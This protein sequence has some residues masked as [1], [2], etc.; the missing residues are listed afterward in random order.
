MC[1][2]ALVW[3]HLSYMRQF[4]L[5][6]FFIGSA[7]AVHGQSVEGVSASLHDR[8]ALLAD[9]QIKYTMRKWGTM[10]N[11]ERFD[12]TET[13]SVAYS[14]SGRYS[15]DKETMVGGSIVAYSVW[16]DG[17]S[18]AKLDSGQKVVFVD[19]AIKDDPSVY[20]WT[21]LVHGP[22]LPL[23]GGLGSIKIESEQVTG[24]KVTI[25]GSAE[26]GASLR[27]VLRIDLGYAPEEIVRSVTGSRFRATWK[28]SGFR[29]VGD[30]WWPSRVT[31]EVSG[32]ALP[33]HSEYNLE[34]LVQGTNAFRRLEHGWWPEGFSVVDGRLGFSVIVTEEKL[35]QAGFK[36]EGLTLDGL[37]EATKFISGQESEQLEREQALAEASRAAGQ[38]N[39]WPVWPLVLGFVA[40]ASLIAV[41]WFRLKMQ[42]RA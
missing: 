28:Y 27:A 20:M 33:S 34:E 11:N 37:L 17:K 21:S 13:V 30:T 1:R 7:V 12:F 38:A 22:C 36:K 3:T 39:R 25:V 9:C 10:S 32:V 26:D 6:L 5:S 23:S 41:V 4:L 8:D 18:A 42:R 31:E 19:R 2:K 29:K 14:S 16:S 24:N 15:Q 35:A 40:I